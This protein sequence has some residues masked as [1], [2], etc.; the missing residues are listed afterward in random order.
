MPRKKV[1]VEAPAAAAATNTSKDELLQYVLQNG[2]DMERRMIYLFHEIDEKTA[3]R[4][5]ATIHH[6]DGTPGEITMI[7]NSIGGAIDDGFAIFDAIR[8]ARNEVMIIGTGSLL[9]MGS[10]LIL[11]GDKRALTPNAQVMI[12]HPWIDPGAQSLSDLRVTMKQ[13][14]RWTKQ[15]QDVYAEK[16]RLSPAEIDRYMKEE[17][18]WTAEEAVKLGFADDILKSSKEKVPHVG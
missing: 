8:F 18:W 4:I 2:A 5:V 1:K 12:H 16:L 6:M 11:A 10:V 15:L 17:T 9:S 7:L 14:E 13:M 3:R